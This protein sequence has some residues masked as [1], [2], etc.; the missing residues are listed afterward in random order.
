MNVGSWMLWG[1]V[2]TVVLTTAL[3]ATQELRLTRVNIPL[4]LGSVFTPERSRAKALGTL[5]HL[6]NGWIFSTFRGRRKTSISWYNCRSRTGP[7]RRICSDCVFVPARTPRR[8]LCRC[9]N[10]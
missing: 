9:A 10:W 3:V 7:Q 8:R 6:V 1:F 5:L 4:L 2:A